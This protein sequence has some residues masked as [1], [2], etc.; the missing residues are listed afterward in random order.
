M[1]NKFKINCS[2]FA[3]NVFAQLPPLV[4]A[5]FLVVYKSSKRKRAVGDV[6]N[7]NR[8][9]RNYPEKVLCTLVITHDNRAPSEIWTHVFSWLQLLMTL[10]MITLGNFWNWPS[11]LMTDLSS[12]MKSLLSPWIFATWIFIFLILKFFWWLEYIC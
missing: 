7:T 10:V 6:F 5:L 11:S 2:R 12:L 1:K 8:V 9:V 4:P 3:L